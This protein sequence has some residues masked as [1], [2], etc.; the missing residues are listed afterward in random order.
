M[1]PIATVAPARIGAAE[2]IQ[3]ARRGL[4]RPGIDRG[5]E[6]GGKAPEA[7]A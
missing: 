7:V 2:R 1:T 5:W 6:F 3:P 4:R